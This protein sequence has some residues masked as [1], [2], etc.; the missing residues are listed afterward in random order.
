MLGVAAG[1]VTQRTLP[2]VAVIVAVYWLAL[3]NVL[4]FE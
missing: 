4:E 2:A 1:A 3:W